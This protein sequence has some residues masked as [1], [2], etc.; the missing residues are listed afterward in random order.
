ML[1]DFEFS[2]F[3]NGVVIG[4]ASAVSYIFSYFTINRIKRK[5][6]AVFSFAAIFVVSFTLIFVWDSN[7]ESLD[8]KANIAILICFFIITLL[9]TV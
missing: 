6:M 1:A 2:I 5:T 8:V 3:L 9:V 4:A 7:G